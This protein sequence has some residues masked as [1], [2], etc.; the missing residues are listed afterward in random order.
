MILGGLVIVNSD[1]SKFNNTMQKYRNE[2]KMTAELKWSKVSWQK[3]DEYRKFID[4]FFALN[5]SDHVH[6]KAL[7]IDTHQLNYK[8]YSSGDKE[9][10]FYKFYY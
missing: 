10:G 1:I 5:N 6:F 3:Y 2:T 8:K 9:V 7:I 4:F